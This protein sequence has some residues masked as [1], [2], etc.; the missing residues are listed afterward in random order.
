[1]KSGFVL[2]AL[3][4]LVFTACIHAQDS[5]KVRFMV[6]GSE[7]YYVRIDGRLMPVGNVFTVG[8]GQHTV[9][10]YSPKYLVHKQEFNTGNVDST[11]L[12]I[13]LNPDPAY[14]S[15]VAARESYK[16]E[17]FFKKTAPFTLALIG[18]LVSPVAV[19]KHVQLHEQLVKNKFYAQ[20]GIVN[21]AT[22]NNIQSRVNLY[23]GL[24]GFSG[25][26][27]IG[28]VAFYLANQKAVKSLDKPVYKQLNPFTG[29]RIEISMFP[30]PVGLA[31]SLTF[32]L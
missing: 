25:M 30:S 31:G 12:V 22:L 2:L 28:G 19:Y 10:V 16:R 7:T 1:M 6:R 8:R 4:W 24:I 18:A 29:E 13:L 27:F 23:T 26:A 17:V 32:R 3:Q 11:N 9:E 5:T 20:Y 21:A 14:V 15:Y